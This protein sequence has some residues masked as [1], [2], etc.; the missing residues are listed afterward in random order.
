[1]KKIEFK[2]YILRMMNSVYV[3]E[4]IIKLKEIPKLVSY[5]DKKYAL[6]ASNP[7]FLLGNA[8]CYFFDID[9]KQLSFIASKSLIKPED[10]DIIVG[11]K[12]IRELTSGVLDNKKDLILWALLG[13]IFGA[14]IMGIVLVMY[15][16]DKMNQMLAESIENSGN[17][18][19]IIPNSVKLFIQYMGVRK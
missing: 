19:P 18:I 9:G 1:M 17:Y 8:Y 14:L 16:S 15:Y 10:L 7:S 13:A 11:Q 12:I 6:D 4:K 3:I 5:Q 2:V